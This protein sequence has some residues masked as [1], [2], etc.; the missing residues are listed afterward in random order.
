MQGFL[1][2]PSCFKLLKLAIAVSPPPPPP[3]SLT[4]Y[5]ISVYSMVVF[6][7][8]NSMLNVGL[9]E[10]ALFIVTLFTMFCLE[11]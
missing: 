6:L 8:L 3:P 11:H 4:N 2:P 9:K 10:T 5:V 7:L 1:G